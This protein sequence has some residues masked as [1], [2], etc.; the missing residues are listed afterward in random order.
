[1]AENLRFYYLRRFQSLVYAVKVHHIISRVH[2]QKK[3]VRGII[4][5]WSTH[6]VN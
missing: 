2:L 4:I 5:L 6:N 3:H 1:M